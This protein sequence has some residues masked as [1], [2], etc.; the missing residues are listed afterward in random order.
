MYTLIAADVHDDPAAMMRRAANC[1]D[2]LSLIFAQ[3]H[4]PDRVTFTPS[5]LDGVATLVQA[6]RG[7][8]CDARA[9]LV[10]GNWQSEE[11]WLEQQE[12]RPPAGAPADVRSPEER[13][14]AAL[15]DLPRKGDPTRTYPHFDPPAADVAGAA[16]E[17]AEPPD[18]AASA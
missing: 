17:G 13:L 15:R 5:Q 4:A 18:R 9:E 10:N 11:M 6:I 14:R 2:A 1:L 3:R 8:V 12:Q 7:T 16:P